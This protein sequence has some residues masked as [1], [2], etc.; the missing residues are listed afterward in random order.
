MESGVLSLQDQIG[1]SPTPEFANLLETTDEDELNLIAALTAADSATGPVV[2]AVFEAAA[3]VLD[4]EI[5]EV[6]F[7]ADLRLADL[8]CWLLPDLPTDDVSWFGLQETSTVM[9]LLAQ[10]D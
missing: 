2:I 5:G 1:V 9:A 10:A 4:A 3:S 6:Q 8:E 7:S